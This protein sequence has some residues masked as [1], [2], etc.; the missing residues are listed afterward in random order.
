MV[1]G[2]YWGT[3]ARTRRPLTATFDTLSEYIG[4]ARADL[5]SGI[6]T[7]DARTRLLR[8][9]CTILELQGIRDGERPF[10]I[11]RLLKELNEKDHR[12][13]P[14]LLVSLGTIFKA[15]VGGEA[16]DVDIAGAMMRSGLKPLFHGTWNADVENFCSVSANAPNVVDPPRIETGDGIFKLSVGDGVVEVGM[17]TIHSVKGETLDAVLVLTTYSYNHDLQQLVDTGL[18][19]GRRPTAAQATQKRLQ[20]NVKRVHVAMTR[21]TR[22]LCLAMREDHVSA[23]QRVEME[24]LGWTFQSVGPAATDL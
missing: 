12:Y 14:E 19:C 15:T 18:L 6:T 22:L 1:I 11:P 21:P 4:A 23:S 13:A 7:A 17:G 10:S 9:A 8:A 24:G 20:E 5:R 2:D 3:G 16:I